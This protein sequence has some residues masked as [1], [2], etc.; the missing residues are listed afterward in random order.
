MDTLADRSTDPT[1]DFEPACA[2]YPS[3]DSDVPG[4]SAGH[5]CDVYAAEERKRRVDRTELMIARA[6][7]NA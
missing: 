3:E 5:L 4:L 6:H 7:E 1:D 2:N